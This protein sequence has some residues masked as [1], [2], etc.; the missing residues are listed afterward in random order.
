MR[1]SIIG[2]LTMAAIFTICYI[3]PNTTIALACTIII[4][5]AITSIDFKNVNRYKVTYADGSTKLFTDAEWST[6]GE[7]VSNMPDVKI[8]KMW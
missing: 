2:F 4:V 6:H 7:W 5:K 1:E 3:A 8:K